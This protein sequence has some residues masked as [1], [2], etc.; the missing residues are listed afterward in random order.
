MANHPIYV[1]LLISML[2][3]LLVYGAWE[4]ARVAGWTRKSLPDQVRKVLTT[5]TLK[6]VIAPPSEEEKKQPEDDPK[7]KPPTQMT[8]VDVDPATASEPPKDAKFYSAISSKAANP[9]PKKDT[10]TPEIDGK[11]KQIV[12]TFEAPRS[13]PK[14]TKAEQPPPVKEQ[15]KAEKKQEE[16]KPVQQMA[17]AQSK[18]EPRPTVKPGRTESSPEPLSPTPSPD[19]KGTAE[20]L[21]PETAPAPAPKQ[22]PRT[23]AAAKAQMGMIAGEKYKQEGGVKRGGIRALDVIG[24]PFGQY[25]QRVIQAIQACWYLLIEEQEA[26]GMVIVSGKVIVSFKLMNDGSVS[27][28][29]VDEENVGP[30]QAILCQQ[31]IIKPAKYDPWPTE[32]RIANSKNYRDVR[33]TFY[34]N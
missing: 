33:F 30:I 13:V 34:Y 29:E 23:I 11:Q 4:V 22:R 24:S 1:A 19:R 21:Q 28:V 20:T 27:N 14:P 12:R 10:D 17:K 32:L 6:V 9:N 25:D 16:T 18:L 26:R 5:P 7:V 2:L 31:A 8:F 15:P 3:H